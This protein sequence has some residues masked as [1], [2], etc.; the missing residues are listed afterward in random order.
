MATQQA[1]LLRVTRRCMP[2]T[3]PSPM[4]PRAEDPCVDA[5]PCGRVGMS[6]D[7][8]ASATGTRAPRRAA[9]L[10]R[11]ASDILGRIHG[12]LE[13]WSAA[14]ILSWLAQQTANDAKLT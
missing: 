8:N 5:L 11:L 3:D 7:E 9:G 1:T 12:G 10:A 4:R 2:A 14:S 6:A 13:Y